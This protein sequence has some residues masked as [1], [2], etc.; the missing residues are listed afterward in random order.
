MII[1]PSDQDI[2]N[3]I[4]RIENNMYDLK[5]DFQRDIVWNKEKQQ[6]LI[7][8]IMRGWH[9]PP[10]HLVEIKGKNYYEVL[11]GKQ[12]LFS[13]LNFYNDEF[14]FKGN[15]L[16]DIGDLKD[17]DRKKYSQFS[18]DSKRKFLFTKIRI[19]EVSDVK[20]NEATELFLRLNLGVAVTASEKRNC[21][22]GPIKNLLHDT[23]QEYP[24]LFC[25]ETLGFSNL[26]MAYQDVLDKIYFLEKNKSLDNKPD[27]RAL[28]KM[29]FEDK[30]DEYLKAELYSNL[31]LLQNVL[32]SSDFKLTKST[33]L[34]Y[35]WFVR[36]KRIENEANELNLRLFLSTFEKWRVTQLQKFEQNDIV[37]PKYIEFQTLLSQGWIDPSSLKGRHKIL[38]DLYND[39]TT[40]GKFGGDI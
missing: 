38:V 12:R 27:S 20:L 26:R 29:Y 39:F 1:V 15:F 2:S 11:D 17:L 32:K 5:P 24:E 18:E 30:V 19:L 25:E 35:Y 9:I 14:P 34:S 36:S 13:I 4:N 21:I 33:I 6:K 23:I 10:I 40:F 37:H 8:S 28:E 22:Y 3:I 31:E 7:D 16:P